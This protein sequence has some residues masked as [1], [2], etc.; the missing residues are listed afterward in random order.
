IHCSA[1]ALERVYRLGHQR[2][3]DANLATSHADE[4]PSLLTQAVQ[5]DVRVSRFA[6]SFDSGDLRVVFPK[7]KRVAGTLRLSHDTNSSSNQNSDDQHER[8]RTC[9]HCS[10]G[11]LTERD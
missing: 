1:G 6:A 10:S 7:L 4:F 8:E 2:I 11:C 3:V 9:T 5:N